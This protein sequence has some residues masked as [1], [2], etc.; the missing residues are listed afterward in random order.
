M[1]H[2]QS[3]DLLVFDMSLAFDEGKKVKEAIVGAVG[4]SLAPGRALLYIDGELKWQEQF[5]A[6]W[7]LKD[8]QFAE[9]CAL[10]VAGEALISNGE[11]PAEEEGGDEEEAIGGD[12]VDD[13]AATGDY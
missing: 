8:G 3:I 6:G 7:A 11:P 1:C 12:F 5:T 9:Q 2:T 13:M 4:G 10:A